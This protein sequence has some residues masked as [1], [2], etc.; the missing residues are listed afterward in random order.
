MGGAAFFQ[1]ALRAFVVVGGVKEGSLKWVM[2]DWIWVAW[3]GL[4]SRLG[5]GVAVWCGSVIGREKGASRVVI[6]ALVGSWKGWE[7]IK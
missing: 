2:R 6:V 1:I 5:K 3:A 4:S 7:R